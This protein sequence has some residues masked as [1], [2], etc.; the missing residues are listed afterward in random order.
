[1][2]SDGPLL[3]QPTHF[4]PTPVGMRF[5]VTTVMRALSNLLAARAAQETGVPMRSDTRSI[6][7]DAPTVD[8]AGFLGNGENLPRWA[9]GFAKEVRADGERWTVTTGEGEMTTT[10][11]LNDAAGTV[12]YRMEPAPGVEA[13]A[14]VRVLPNGSGTEVVFT[15][16]QQEGVPD[17]VFEQLIEAVRHELV[18]LKALME[19]ACP[20]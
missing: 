3:V 12:D 20:L 10:I 17:D 19:V 18:T 1:M 5:P 13:T 14:F 8:V 15:Q 16:F 9:I 4:S 2:S 7:I 6:T 11:V